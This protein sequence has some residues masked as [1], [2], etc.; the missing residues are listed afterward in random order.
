MGRN[1]DNK[2]VVGITGGGGAKCNEFSKKLSCIERF[3]RVKFGFSGI[4]F[5]I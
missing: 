5:V 2:C 4:I 1:F 3:N